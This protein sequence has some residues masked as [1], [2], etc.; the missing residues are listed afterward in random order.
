[1]GNAK[2]DYSN[3]LKRFIHTVAK[4]TN[5]DKEDGILG[6][7]LQMTGGEREVYELIVSEGY[8]ITFVEF[9]AYYKA[10]QAGI[11]AVSTELSDDELDNVAGGL[12]FNSIKKIIQKAASTVPAVTAGGIV[13]G[14]ACTVVGGVVGMGT[15]VIANEITNL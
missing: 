4:E 13:G 11:T 3:E 10:C 2:K 7:L 8:N 14:G 12:D 1:M 6:K 5:A 9:L 15:M